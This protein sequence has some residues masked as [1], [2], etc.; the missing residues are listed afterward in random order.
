M[1]RV[2]SDLQPKYVLGEN[3]PGFINLP[4]GIERTSSDLEK[5]YEV[6]TFNI[7]ACAVTLAHER[8]RVWII[9]KRKPMGNT[10]HS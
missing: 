7:P 6:A 9:A 8:K 1:F 2:I 4:M 5:E 3:V 10:E